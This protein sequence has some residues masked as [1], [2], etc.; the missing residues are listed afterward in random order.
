MKN[1]TID[2]NQAE[3]TVNSKINRIHLIVDF[4]EKQS[5]K[6][7]NY[8]IQ[9]YNEYEN[10]AKIILKKSEALKDIIQART[11]IEKE[12]LFDKWLKTKPEFDLKFL[13]EKTLKDN[14][15]DLIS[16]VNLNISYTFDEKFVL[17]MI[18]N[19]YSQYLRN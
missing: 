6:F 16:S 18:E 13:N 10:S 7:T 1:S 15:D 4:L 14:F 8:Q 19:K 3:K 5:K 2:H 17:W 12:R 9:I 11:F